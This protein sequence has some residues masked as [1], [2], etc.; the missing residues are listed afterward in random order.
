MHLQ[1]NQNINMF[2]LPSCCDSRIYD[3]RKA[4][5]PIWINVAHAL[6]RKRHKLDTDFCYVMVQVR[7]G[8]KT[9]ADAAEDLRKK[10]KITV[11]PN[12]IYKNSK[13]CDVPRPVGRPLLIPKE[14]ELLLARVIVQ[15]RINLLATQ[16]KVLRMALW[17]TIKGSDLEPLC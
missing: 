1:E 5:S 3:F 4:S 10:Y 16:P 15:L 11:Q 7:E 2:C 17:G 9:A 13:C 6:S 8:K 12:T 14:Q